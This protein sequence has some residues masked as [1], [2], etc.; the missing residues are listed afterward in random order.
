M[1]AN[2][3]KYKAIKK[4]ENIIRE[5]SEF[6]SLKYN[7][8]KFDRWKK[9]LDNFIEDLLDK[10]SRQFKNYKRIKYNPT[11]Q[12]IGAQYDDNYYQ[13]FYDDGLDEA[14]KYFNQLIDEL[15]D[16]WN[17]TSDYDNIIAIQPTNDDENFI[18]LAKSVREKIE[19]NEPEI[20]LDHLHT[21][22][23]KYFRELCLT[24]DVTFQKDTPLHSLFGSYLKRINE[25][26]KI[27]SDLSKNILKY[28]ISILDKYND[29]RNNNSFA[30]D[31]DLVKHNEAKL[32]FNYIS[33]LI[34]FINTIEE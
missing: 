2:I 20:A 33:N 25:E 4:L 18:K 27:E 16:L 23:I 17:V 6:K 29:I 22:L 32:I 12:F 13:G 11:F 19:N 34:Q 31:N 15:R 30:H 7:N 26:G 3:D 9:S 1:K 5:I 14:D 21:Y 28:S 10:E 24:Y 8:D